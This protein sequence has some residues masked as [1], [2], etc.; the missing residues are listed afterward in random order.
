[1]PGGQEAEVTWDLRMG[2]WQDVLAGVGE[3]DEV[4]TDPPYSPRVGRKE[5]EEPEDRRWRRPETR[6]PRRRSEL[7]YKPLSEDIVRAAVASFAVR[8]WWVVF[9]DHESMRWW[10]DALA[11]AGLLTFPPVPWVRVDAPPRYFCD[12][13]SNACEWI[14]IARPRRVPGDRRWRPGVYT[15]SLK[16]TGKLVTGGKPLWLMR[17]LV[18]DYSEPGDVVCDPFAGGGTT[19]LAAAIEGRR[20]VGAECDPETFAKAQSRLSRGYTPVLPGLAVQP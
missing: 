9:G 5:Q 14:T 16:D 12:G 10:S 4:I 15:G 8:K 1:M 18:R 17:A 19:L 20:A 3:V 7:A 6:M 2:R 13:P 11:E